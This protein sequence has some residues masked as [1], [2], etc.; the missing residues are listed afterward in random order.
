VLFRSGLIKLLQ[1]FAKVPRIIAIGGIS[2]AT[3]MQEFK[4][5]DINSISRVVVDVGNALM[6]CLAKGTKI[7]M[8]DGTLKNVEDIN[9]NDKVMGLNSEPRTVEKSGSGFEEM[10][11]VKNKKDEIVYTCN[12]SHIMTLKYCSDDDRYNAKKGQIIDISVIDYLELPERQKRLLMGFKSS[13]EFDRKDIPL[14]A[15]GFG[16]WLGDGHSDR[17]TIT[18]SDLVLEEYWKNLATSMGYNVYTYDQSPGV[19]QIG[20]AKT[21]NKCHSF[22]IKELEVYKN[23]HIPYVYKYN[24]HENLLSLLAGFIDADGTLVDQT[25]VIEQKSDIISNDIVFIARSLGFKCNIRKIDKVCSF[26]GVESIHNIISIGGDTWRIPTKL[27]RK[28]SK[29][30]EKQKDWLNYGIKLESIG[31]GE[32]FGFTLKEDPHFLLG[33]FTVTHNTTAGRAQIAENL[34]QMG[35]IKSPEKYLMVLNTGNLDYLMEGE[36]NEL[37]TINAENEA[38]LKG[39]EVISVIT[40][41]HALHIKEHKAVIADPVLRRDPDLLQR[42]ISHIQEHIELLRTVDPGLLAV[43][44]QQPL[45]PAQPPIPPQQQNVPNGAMGN[46]DLLNNPQA[47]S[48]AVADQNQSLPSIPAPPAPFENSPQTP[49]QAMTNQLG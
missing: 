44:Q 25:F 41:D 48:V 34:L 11:N 1:D 39:D 43:I 31:F 5:E 38:L 12:R 28:Q 35:L 13:V 49:Q 15:Y 45:P 26:N 21:E 40:D 30:V 6:Q 36:M 10:F 4:S 42:T 47:Q 7:L 27:E 3:K 14:D 23:K 18:T 29:V 22:I 33:D 37:D 24:N 16:L 19:K 32:Y 9:V 8:A 46:Q 17:L 2:Q 20:F